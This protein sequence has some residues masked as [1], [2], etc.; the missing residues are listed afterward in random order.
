MHHAQRLARALG[1][2]GEVVLLGSIATGKYIFPLQEALGSRLYFPSEFVGRGDMSRGSLL[3]RHARAEVELDYTR[4]PGAAK[5]EARSP[6]LP[7]RRD[8]HR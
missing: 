4:V 8:S 1:P 7:G 2:R 5:R 3:L 6:F